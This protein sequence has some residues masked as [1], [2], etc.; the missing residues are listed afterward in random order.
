MYEDLKGC[1]RFC[2][3]LFGSW[4]GMRFFIFTNSAF[5]AIIE[6]Q[7]GMTVSKIKTVIK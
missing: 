1:R 5:T 4:R 6:L 3:G 2:G 7:E